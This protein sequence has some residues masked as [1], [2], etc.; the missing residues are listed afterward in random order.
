[1]GGS[2]TIFINRENIGGPYLMSESRGN[3]GGPVNMSK[4]SNPSLR[5]RAWA[6]LTFDRCLSNFSKSI[7]LWLACIN[8]ISCI[9]HLFHDHVPRRFYAVAGAAQNDFRLV[10]LRI[11]CVWRK[12][13]IW[14]RC[15]SW[16]PWSLALNYGCDL[17]EM[18][19]ISKLST[20]V[21]GSTSTLHLLALLMAFTCSSKSSRIFERQLIADSLFERF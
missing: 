5:S 11:K 21:S 16:P 4:S 12:W 6:S 17:K 14:R 20:L 18:E 7:F 10:R 9:F 15:P 2:S 1:M 8:I 13:R 19:N 3:T